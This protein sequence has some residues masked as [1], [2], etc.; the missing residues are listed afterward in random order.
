VKANSS[1]V[2]AIEKLVL[3]AEYH[4][5]I[6]RLSADVHE[7]SD[8]I[9]TILVMVDSALS[10]V[11]DAAIRSDLEEIRQSAVRAIM[12]VEPLGKPLLFAV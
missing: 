12:K 7:I 9:Q 5:D 11:D 2:S 6:T 4:D 8:Q 1:I 3:M 10:N